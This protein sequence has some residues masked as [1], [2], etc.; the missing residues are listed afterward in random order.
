MSQK[1][2]E[3]LFPK[4]VLAECQ[5]TQ[6]WKEHPGTI[7]RGK[8]LG[9]GAFGNVFGVTLKMGDNE[10]ALAYKQVNISALEAANP[11][12]WTQTIQEVGLMAQVYGH[13]NIVAMYGYQDKDRREIG[14]FMQLCDHSLRERWHRNNKNFGMV[15]IKWI[16]YC[17]MNGLDHC[18]SSEVIHCDIKMEN[19]LIY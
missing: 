8:Q 19:V 16:M 11:D 5:W 2:N 3:I 14:I 12:I 1:K 15:E 7:S 17:I 18:H 13:T 10:R 9:S 6:D 4:R